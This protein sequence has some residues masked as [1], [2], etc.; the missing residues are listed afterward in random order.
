MLIVTNAHR[1]DVSRPVGAAVG[2]VRIGLRTRRAIMI[3]DAPH[4]M[5]TAT[6]ITV[7]APPLGITSETV[8]AAV[9]AAAAR[10]MEAIGHGTA[11]SREAATPA[12]NAR[13]A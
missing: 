13:S 12:S 5:T 11:T 10:Q 1:D 2:L 4:A 8:V 3:A 7:H 9:A 6:R